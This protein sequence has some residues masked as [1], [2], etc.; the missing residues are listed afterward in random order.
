MIHSSMPGR[1]HFDTRNKE[2]TRL[3]KATAKIALTFVCLLPLLTAAQSPIGIEVSRPGIYIVSPP[4]TKT[5]LTAKDFQQLTTQIGD[6][7]ATHLRGFFIQ[8]HQ[9]DP[10]LVD[11]LPPFGKWGV[12]KLADR[13]E[14]L[15][16]AGDLLFQQLASSLFPPVGKKCPSHTVLD[17]G[18][19]ALDLLFYQTRGKELRR[20]PGEA[21]LMTGTLFVGY[22]EA[23]CAAPS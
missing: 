10:S 12:P 6:I 11:Q 3:V 21:K 16:I 13:E 18:V 8:L 19:F 1:V 4:A 23:A 17:N 22:A 2:R 14:F 20:I 5:H 7:D 9:L 15:G